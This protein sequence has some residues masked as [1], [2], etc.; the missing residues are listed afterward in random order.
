[1]RSAASP[2]W[3]SAPADSRA[4]SSATGSSTRSR[5]TSCWWGSSVRWRSMPT[6]AGRGGSRRAT[7]GHEI[8]TIESALKS[9][10]FRPAGLRQRRRQAQR[11]LVI[12]LLQHGI[13]Q[14]DAVQLPER[15]IV[16]VV[17]EVVVARL[18]HPP[19]VRILLGL[20]R[21]L[22]E[23]QPVLVRDEEVVRRAR[24]AADVVE[25]RADLGVDVR[26][27][28]EHLAEPSQIVGLPP[29]VRGD[30]RR[31][32]MLLEETVALSH[33]LFER[34]IFAGRVAAIAEQRE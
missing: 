33:Q 24:L 32:R 6:P 30:E 15:V 23:E 17:V 11:V 18:E 5:R 12:E 28:V 14:I 27:R 7:A 19:V 21:I 22:A 1:M 16:P 20:E 8:S 25:D 13:W 29:H 9:W 26:H 2:S 3:S 34:G 10:L 31:L 4:S